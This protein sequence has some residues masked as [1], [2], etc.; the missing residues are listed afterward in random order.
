MNFVWET[1]EWEAESFILLNFVLPRCFN[2]RLVRVKAEGLILGLLRCHLS[3][4]VFSQI[5][6]AE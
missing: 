2:C 1:D 5:G 3:V 4:A 6:S